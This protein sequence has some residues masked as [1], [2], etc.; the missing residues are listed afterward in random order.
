MN[1]LKDRAA[2]VGIGQSAFGKA[3]DGTEESLAI[4]A[5]KVAR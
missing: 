2:I 1:L 3:L 5:I 4:T